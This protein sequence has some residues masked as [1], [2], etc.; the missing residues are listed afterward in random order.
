M[1]QSLNQSLNQPLNRPFSQAALSTTDDNAPESTQ[2]ITFKVAEYLFALRSLEILKIVETPPPS[3][4]GLVKMGMVQLGPYSIQM[5]DLPSLLTLQEKPDKNNPRPSVSSSR[6]LENR[7]K[8]SFEKETEQNPPFLVV[9]QN[10]EQ[11]L[12]GIALHEPPDLM[13][14]PNYALKPVPSHQRST[15]ALRWVSHI[16]NYDL[17]SNRHSLLI[18]DLSMVLAPKRSKPLVDNNPKFREIKPPLDTK[19]ETLRKSEMYI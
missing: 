6:S 14:I 9:L 12:W 17:N 1:N 5:I 7:K 3:Q 2:Y 13:E 15:R 8:E 10:S 16:V 4:G 11:D 18:L 19:L